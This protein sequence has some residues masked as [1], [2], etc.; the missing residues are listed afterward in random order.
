MI[1][2]IV[3]IRGA[4]DICSIAY[5]ASN[6]LVI[7]SSVKFTGNI[8]DMAS[9]GTVSITGNIVL[10]RLS[11]NTIPFIDASGKLANT[12]V[13]PTELAMLRGIAGPIQSQLDAHSFGNAVISGATSNFITSNMAP[14]VVVITD[15]EG[16]VYPS[17][18]TTTELQYLRGVSGNIQSQLDSKQTHLNYFV[19]G[20][21]APLNVVVTDSSGKLSNS[22]VSTTSLGF[23]GNL[24]GDAQFQLDAKA[25][26]IT[27]AASTVTS[28]DLSAN[29]LLITNSSGKIAASGVSSAKA[30]YLSDVTSSIQTQL[31]AKQTTLTGA[32]STVTSANLP[33]GIVL[34]SSAGGKIAA[35]GTLATNLGS[36]AGVTTNIQDQLDAKQAIVTG[37]ASSIV[38]SDLGRDMVLVSDA[39]GKV[40]TGGATRVE[41]AY[42]ASVTGP[43]QTQLDG[44]EDLLTGAASSVTRINLNPFSVPVTD[45]FGKFQNSG[46]SVD[47]LVDVVGARGNLQL[48][49]DGK[50]SVITG[51]ATLILDN[52][53]APNVVMITNASG[54]AYNSLVSVNELWTLSGIRTNI[55]TALDSTQGTITGAASSITASNLPVEKVL[56]SDANGKVSNSSVTASEVSFVVGLRSAAQT[57]IDAK[58]AIITGAASSITSADLSPGLVA[59]SSGSGKLIASDVTSAELALLSGG[60]TNSLSSLA[61]NVTGLQ[62]NAAAQQSG[63]VL[64]QGNVAAAQSGIVNLQTRSTNLE[65]NVTT[66]QTGITTLQTRSTNLEA[67]VTTTQ[68]GIT[69]LQTRSSNLESNVSATQTGITALQTRSTNLEANVALTQNGIVNLQTRSTN[70]ES[71][72][73]LTQ[74]GIGLL[75]TRSTNLESNVALTQNGITALQTRS[76]NLE[77]NVALTQNGIGALQTRSTNLESNVALTQNGIGALQTRSTNL[78]ANVAISQNGI[79][80]LQTRSTNLESNVAISQNGILAL[81]T[82]STNLEANVST[83]QTGIVNLQTRSTSLESNV[84][85]L[86]GN[87]ITTASQVTALQS[88]LAGKQATL[89]GGITSFQSSNLRANIVV[90]SDASGKMA[91]SVVSTA[92]L[93]CLTGATSNIQLQINNLTLGGITGGA[94][95]VAT[96]DL[97]PDI[98]VISND[99]GKIVASPVTAIELSRL[100]GVSGNVETSLTNL[101]AN[102][103]AAQTGILNLQTRSTNL[104]ANVATAQTGILALQANV[105]TAQT[106]ITALQTRS[107]NL[108]ANVATAQTGITALQTRSTNLESNVAAAQTGILALQAN[109]ATA[110]TGIT[111]LQTRSTNLE[112]NVATT[113]TGITAL[114]TRSTNLEAN[115]ATAQ[116]GITALQTRSTN[117][118]ANVATAQTGITALQTRST[119]LEANVATAQTGILALQANVSTAQTGITALQTRS[120]NLES[121]VAITQ[122]GITALQTRS[123]NLEAN[124][125]ATQTGI[126]AL[127]TR[128]TN[129]EANVSATQTGITALQTRS[130]NLE[131]NV[132]ATQ[133]G[134]T[135]LQTRSTNLEANVSA[136]QTQ[137][138]TKQ[139]LITGSTDLTAGTLTIGSS[140]STAMTGQYVYLARSADGGA[141]TGSSAVTPLG[142]GISAVNGSIQ[143]AQFVAVSDARIKK[144]AA[145]ENTMKLAECVYALPVKTWRYVDDVA[146]G[147]RERLGF[148][149]QDVRNAGRIGEYAVSTHSDFL[150]TIYERGSVGIDGRVALQKPHGFCVGDRVRY[151]TLSESLEA[152]VTRIV[153][154][155]EF[156]MDGSPGLDR[157]TEIFVYGP[158]ASDVLSIDYDAIVAGLVATVQDQNR[159]LRALESRLI[160]GAEREM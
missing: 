56:V 78:E 85:V 107:T 13:T 27:G 127:Q 70:L 12:S 100:R 18:V 104:E 140:S 81:Q 57:Q 157:V 42:L 15:S 41:T 117:L 6:V 126:T 156:Y 119:N 138:A 118:E 112:S 106:G 33:A 147:S 30:S 74:N 95:T 99:L 139:N 69:A 36:L 37:A 86:Q 62:S 109:V 102:T 89:T 83:A 64:L 28:L 45:A 154:N 155:T 130:T 136:A 2:N 76:T 146:K 98:V 132:S 4:H 22:S 77:S 54:K 1:D 153:S 52:D 44:K 48:Q 24:T 53:L 60:G 16:K 122:T 29:A 120:T 5:S 87:S 149:A 96:V 103:T 32:A 123:T 150:P 84:S 67:N 141:L 158:F 75:Q 110:Q 50:Q 114:Q 128:S 88:G 105:A 71:N 31:D 125:S 142:I 121:N 51:A 148:I 143:A 65:A 55:Q 115:V 90:V 38:T 39:G 58:Q 73:A 152:R 79:V 144:N 17:A 23:I 9:E 133:T 40:T 101:T 61:A 124:V 49:I 35:S 59:V 135:A 14:N 10:P 34:I 80:T 7:S 47:D 116:T 3:Q 68:N 63:L 46:V 21:L 94:S 25:P 134:I 97:S 20:N 151:F 160:P 26:A 8:V 111:A 43:I 92:E 72:V 159:R 131:A 145:L 113:Q 108:E 91:N 19:T 66:T 82:R 93:A 137:I 129:L 11:P